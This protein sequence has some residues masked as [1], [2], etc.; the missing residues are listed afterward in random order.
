MQLAKLDNGQLITTYA[1]DQDRELINLMVADGFKIY[2]EEAQQPLPLSEFQSQQ[3][4]YRDEG[5][6]IVGYYEIVDNSPEKVAAEIERLKTELTST[7]YQI[8]KSYE[9]TLAAQPLPY[10]L[11]SLHSERQQLREQIQKLERMN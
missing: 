7:D 1:E 2:V 10:D 8:I 4:C 11:G 3:L 5:F 9:Y 6:Q